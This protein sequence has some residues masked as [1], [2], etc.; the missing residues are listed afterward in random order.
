[1]GICHGL[2]NLTRPLSRNPKSNRC[3]QSKVAILQF[4]RYRTLRSDV[5]T[6]FWM[7]AVVGTKASR[8]RRK[9]CQKRAVVAVDRKLAVLLHKLWVS[10]EVY[11]PLRNN[12]KAVSAVA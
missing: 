11:E 4:V 2:G 3:V 5:N 6:A 7:P 1:M 10:G 9:R 12:H 8:A